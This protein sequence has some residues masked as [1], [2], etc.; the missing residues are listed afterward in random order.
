MDRAAF[1]HRLKQS[2]LLSEELLGHVAR[3]AEEVAPEDLPTAL[4]SDGIL[5]P[6]Q[7][8]GLAS[9]NGEP[10]VI[11]PYQL[12]EEVGRGG[13]GRVYKALHTV[14]GRVVALKVIAP[15]RAR[16]ERARDLFLREVR[17]VTRLNHPNVV[18]AHDANEAD[19]VLYLAMEYVEGRPLDALVRSQG[20]LDAA[21]ACEVVRQAARGLQHAHEMGVIH[22]DI[23]PSNLL[24]GCGPGGGA[25]P[26]KEDRRGHL[27]SE[28]VVKIADFGLARLQG[29]HGGDTVA[30]GAAGGFLGTPDYVAPEQCSDSRLADCRS[31]LYSLGCTLFFALTGRP[32]F[33]EGNVMEKLMQHATA[34]PPAL[35]AVRADVPAGLA[36]VV[37]RLL[38]K[39]PNRRFQTAAELA[40]A[41]APWCDGGR[42]R[43]SGPAAGPASPGSPVD[44]TRVLGQEQPARPVP[45]AAEGPRSATVVLPPAL[46]AGEAVEVGPTVP[47]PDTAALRDHWGRWVG[48]L[49]AVV[50]HPGRVPCGEQAYRELYRALAEGCAAHAAHGSAAERRV[51]GR[52]EELVRP[53]LSLTILVR[54]DAA[55]LRDLARRAREAGRALGVPAAQ[56]WLPW[57]GAAALLAAGM[58]LGLLFV[59]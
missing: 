10:L 5:T 59:R 57:L 13:M 56:P 19:G 22:R 4:V 51:F 17:S 15:E 43:L 2:R 9:G 14:M 47:P 36:A 12:L 32:P 35:Q 34:P 42:L 44:A 40:A 27:A 29:L 54:T 20:P 3:L 38:A 7:A 55:L 48:L 18:L 39:E 37:A 46:P 11:G 52:M 30:Q 50:R 1:L 53:W 16:A 25:C 6:L 45:P 21:Q 24:I 41:L 8:H 58:L 23:K 31:D 33:A 49:E 28:V 26:G